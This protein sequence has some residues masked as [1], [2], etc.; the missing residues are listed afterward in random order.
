[1][2]FLQDTELGTGGGYGSFGGSSS[3]STAALPYGD[4]ITP[5]ERGSGAG[6]GLTGAAGRGGGLLNI[7]MNGRLVVDGESG[8]VK[9]VLEEISYDHNFC[10]LIS[11]CI[12]CVRP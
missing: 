9:F 6:F 11:L 5:S 8:V 10:K 2:C 4:F 3:G 12:V 1:M 7:T